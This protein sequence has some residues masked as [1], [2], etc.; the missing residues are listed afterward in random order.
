MVYSRRRPVAKRNKYVRRAPPRRKPP[1][2][3]RRKVAGVAPS[4]MPKVRVAHLRYVQRFT[5]TPQAD[6]GDDLLQWLTFRANGPETPNGTATS[7]SAHIEPHQPMGWDRWAALFNN[8]V[9]K[10][11]KITVTRYGTESSTEPVENISGAGRFGAYLSDSVAPIYTR[12]TYFKEARKGSMRYVMNQQRTAQTV[13][14]FFSPR[15]MYG[16]KDIKD[17]TDRLG[18]TV[19]NVPSELAN[20]VIWAQIDATSTL[21]TAVTWVFEAT[22]EYCVQFDEPVDLVPSIPSRKAEPSPE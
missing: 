9:V 3:R 6:T 15:R 10:G 2:R 20:F 11:S 13:K 17:N 18:A 22:I 16:I 19:N 21:P 8:Y 5:M 4:G 14:A 7:G 12:G 1:P